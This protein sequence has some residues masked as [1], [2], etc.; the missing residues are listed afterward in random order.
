MGGEK[1]M[2]Q[3]INSDVDQLFQVL[4]QIHLRSGKISCLYSGRPNKPYGLLW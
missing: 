3:S 2:E 4:P 1:G